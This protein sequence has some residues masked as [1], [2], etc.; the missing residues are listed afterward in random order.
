AAIA[1]VLAALSLLTPP[2]WFFVTAEVMCICAVLVNTM[3]GHR[4]DWHRRWVQ[5]RE[6]AERLRVALPLWA[7]CTRPVSFPG[8]EPSWIG[9]YVRA[10]VRQLG[11]R[12]G[13][14]IGEQW[15]KAKESVTLLLI[16]QCEYHMTITSP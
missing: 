6:V 3:V 10:L 13:S 11:L 15:T 14:L 7:L 4:R 16:G 9:W 2:K 5:P 1:V 12:S 8:E